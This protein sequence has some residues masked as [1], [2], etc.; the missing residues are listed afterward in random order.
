MVC[1]HHRPASYLVQSIL[2]TDGMVGNLQKSRTGP[3]K[4][5][6]RTI[7]R[8]RSKFHQLMT[9]SIGAH[10]LHPARG[11]GEKRSYVFV[12]VVN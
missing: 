6:L 11:R 1:R 12:S 9:S 8:Q 5:Y 7:N 4:P 3:H 2:R 10:R